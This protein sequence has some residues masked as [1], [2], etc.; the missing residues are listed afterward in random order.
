MLDTRQQTVESGVMCTIVIVHTC[1]A[2]I[3]FGFPFPVPVSLVNRMLETH[4]PKKD[5]HNNFRYK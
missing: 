2:F 1:H 4:V 3:C 5:I